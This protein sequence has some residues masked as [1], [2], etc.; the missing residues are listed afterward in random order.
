M[1]DIR[2]LVHE[3]NLYL[4]QNLEYQ[5]LI[6]MN[7]EAKSQLGQDLFVLSMSKFL[8][9]G[10]FVE[11]GAL[12][13]VTGS[14]SFLLESRFG[15]KGILVEPIPRMHHRIK[16]AR[17]ATL[18][19]RALWSQTGVSMRFRETKTVGL[20]VFEHLAGEDSHAESRKDVAQEYD[21]MT[22]SLNDLLKEH[23]AP[24]VIDYLSLDTEGSELQILE[25]FSFKDWLVRLITVEHNNSPQR[26]KIRSFLTSLGY[27]LS[28]FCNLSGGDDWFTLSG[29][30]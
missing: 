14:N 12:D 4:R 13:G 11:A 22:V 29:E 16:I 28:S 6:S 3:R 7:G 1:M 9:G 23:S 26:D 5:K 8:R 21:V 19:T 17:S 25:A 20:S 10:F 24:H 15:W 18:D 27:E 30:I 2:H